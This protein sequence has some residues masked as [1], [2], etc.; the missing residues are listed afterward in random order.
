MN[1]LKETD[2][3]IALEV[4][5]A[6]SDLNEG[7]DDIYKLWKTIRKASIESNSKIYQRLGVWFDAHEWES[8]HHITAK[9]LCDQLLSDGKLEYIDGAYCTLL[10]D[11]RGKLQKVVLLKGNGSTLYISRDVA[12][13]LSRYK[14]YKFDKMLYV[15]C[16]L[17][18]LYQ[19]IYSTISMYLFYY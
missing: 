7:K 15:V 17:L 4:E 8:D 18:L 19:Y 11:K 12:A 1:R 5:R 3:S 16:L 14:K 2:P 6:G 13:F 10:E 9:K